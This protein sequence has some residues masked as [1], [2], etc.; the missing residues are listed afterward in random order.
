MNMSNVKITVFED[1]TG[2]LE[3]L[4]ILIN[5]L[6][7]LELIGAYTDTC[8]ILDRLR[9]NAPDLVLMDIEIGPLNGIESTRLILQHYPAIK[10]LIETVFEED[11][12]VFGA[13]CA[14]ATGYILKSELPDSLLGFI[15]E[16]M[17]GG[18]P[19]SPI[20]ARKILTLFRN[21]FLKSYLK[22]DYN[23]SKREKEILKWMVDGAS[24]KMVADKCGITYETVKSHIKN[25]Y[26][27]LQV[28][29]MTEA[30]A[31]AIHENLI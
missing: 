11:N 30:V 15:S 16:V 14:G 17:K 3:A 20:V 1:N 10:I 13:I 19:M 29:S 25:I 5:G 18:A 22:E 6:P 4:S 27:K 26:G 24:Y 31:K 7:G 12:K 21:Y 28:A 2:F 8:H 9:T 23:L